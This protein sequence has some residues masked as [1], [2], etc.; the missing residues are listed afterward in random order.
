MR[1]LAARSFLAP[2]A[3]TWTDGSGYVVSALDDVNGAIAIEFRNALL[4]N[5]SELQTME[6]QT[7]KSV[8]LL[9]VGR[10]AGKDFD[11]TGLRVGIGIE[12]LGDDF[13]QMPDRGVHQ[14]RQFLLAFAA[15]RASSATDPFADGR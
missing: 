12:P 1:F 6:R 3:V 10:G 2:G 15:S 11:Q 9:Q 5:F 8:P 13:G 14:R 4:R 7:Q